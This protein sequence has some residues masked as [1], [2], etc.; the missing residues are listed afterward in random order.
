M[1]ETHR[2]LRRSKTGF[3][4][5][6]RRIPDRLRLSFDN[7]REFKKALGT[8]SYK[9]AVA[10]WVKANKEFEALAAR[11]DRVLTSPETALTQ[12]VIEEATARA[13]LLEPP[14]LRAGATPAERLAFEEEEKLWLATLE[15]VESDLADRYL[16]VKK[17]QDDYD[18][19]LWGKPGYQE[20]Y[21]PVRHDDPDILAYEYATKGA[22]I[23]LKPTWRD[24]VETYLKL[25]A[26]DKGRDTFQQAQYEKKMRSLLEKF[27]R[28]LGKQGAKTPL[29]AITKQQARDF[30]D[31]FG[32]STG[33]RY[34]NVLS[35]VLNTW[36]K[37]Y[38]EKAVKN[39][40]SGLTNKKLEDQ[41][42]KKRR[43]FRPEQWNQYVNALASHHNTEIGLIGLIMAYTGCRNSDAAGL[44]LRDV[45]LDGDV[46]NLVFRSNTVRTLRKGGLQRAVPI[47]DPLLAHL[48]AYKENRAT[49]ADSDAF[50][51][52]YGHPRHL[53]NISQQLNDIRRKLNITSAGLVA[54]S[55][56]H[57][58]H[59]TGRA[60]KVDTGI[61]EYI[62]GHLSPN[63][64]R[65][66]Q[67]YGTRPPPAALAEDMKK[68]IEQ[69]TW[70]SDF[71]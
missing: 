3:Y 70:D 58:I 11:G 1:P 9:E 15:S 5:Y 53:N 54:Y 24:A 16:D 21:L 38:P 68:I 46:P 35:A 33:N 18:K 44:E 51:V 14:M 19:G 17:R 45:R 43:S 63:S 26:S 10:G 8:T 55:F 50:F 48:K 37:E 56:R 39:H 59:D 34:N 4:E 25:N 42:S 12:E 30:K 69:K 32:V 71:D 13:R 2:Y 31:Q 57:T 52:K 64:S 61:Q 47:F 49:T 7:K 60:A 65:I 23:V 67:G 20:P 29:G 6:R 40:F 27:G 22:P 41:T 28:S 62:V 36:N 66:H